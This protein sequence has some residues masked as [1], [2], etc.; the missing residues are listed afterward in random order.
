MIGIVV[1]LLG[2][3]PCPSA[4]MNIGII[5]ATLSGLIGGVLDWLFHRVLHG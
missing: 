1:I 4:T 3:S 2:L 5:I